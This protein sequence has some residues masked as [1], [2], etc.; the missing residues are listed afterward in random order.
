MYKKAI[1]KKL[2]LRQVK[3]T[4]VLLSLIVLILNSVL[5]ESGHLL[6]QLQQLYILHPFLFLPHLD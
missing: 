1:L 3:L 6:P 2:Y 5:Q 4:D